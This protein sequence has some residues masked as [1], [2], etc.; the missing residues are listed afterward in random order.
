M[1]SGLI[2]SLEILKPRKRREVLKNLHFESFIFSL[3]F[4]NASKTFFMFSRW[5]SREVPMI[6]TSSRKTLQA[7][8]KRLCKHNSINLA[9][10]EGALANPKFKRVGQYCPLV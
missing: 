6:I 5:F 2:P 7:S 9:N 1:G 4:R 3:F 10:A 8:S